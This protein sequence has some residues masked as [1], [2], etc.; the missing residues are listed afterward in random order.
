ML[1]SLSLK[2]FAHLDL[3]DLFTVLA[4]TASSDHFSQLYLDGCENIDDNTL[5]PLSEEEPNGFAGLELLSL[6]ECRKLSDDGLKRIAQG[7]P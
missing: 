3:Q 7:C 1:Q 4:S 2:F 6:A 5:T